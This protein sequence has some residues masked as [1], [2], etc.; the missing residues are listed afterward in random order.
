MMTSVDAEQALNKILLLFLIKNSQRTRN[1]RQLPQ[2][3][4]GSYENPTA[5]IKPNDQR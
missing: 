5:N 3:I 2:L 1:G 4:N